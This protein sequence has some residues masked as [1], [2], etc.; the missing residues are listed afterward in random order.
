MTGRDRPLR[1]FATKILQRFVKAF[2]VEFADERPEVAADG[3]VGVGIAF[4]EGARQNNANY[5]LILIREF[6]IGN[7]LAECIEFT[8]TTTPRSRKLW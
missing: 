8:Q 6:V 4:E 5:A 1:V 3:A 7:N 2:D